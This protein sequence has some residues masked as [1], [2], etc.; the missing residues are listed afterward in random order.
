VPHWQ[1][2]ALNALGLNASAIG[3]AAVLM[4]VKIATVTGVLEIS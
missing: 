4:K 2:F 1:I 3:C